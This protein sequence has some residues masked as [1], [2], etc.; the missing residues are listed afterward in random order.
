MRPTDLNAVWRQG[1]ATVI[2][3]PMGLPAMDAKRGEGME[4]L[5]V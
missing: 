5:A 2:G 1:T 4:C 3:H